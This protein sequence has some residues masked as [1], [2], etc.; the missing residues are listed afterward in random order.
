[1]SQEI[2]R[3]KNGSN[4]DERI[5]S[6]M[7]GAVIG[8]ILWLFYGYFFLTVLGGAFCGFFLA[9]YAQKFN[10]KTASLYISPL[11]FVCIVTLVTWFAIP[12]TEGAKLAAFQRLVAKYEQTPGEYA[13]YDERMSFKAE[14]W[15][16]QKSFVQIEFDPKLNRKEAE[17]IIELYRAQIENKY[18]GGGPPMDLETYMSEMYLKLTD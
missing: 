1:M 18:Q 4:N 12:A 8:L 5:G 9:V 3:H 6:A 14:L 11:A 16:V 13:S 15:E 10:N 2:P 7:V 17:A